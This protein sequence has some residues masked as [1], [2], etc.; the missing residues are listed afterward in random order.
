MGRVAAKT[1]LGPTAVVAVEQYFPQN[2]RILTDELAQ[3]IL[4]FSGRLFLR[5]LRRAWARDWMVRIAA[6]KARGLWTMMLCRKRYID[7]RLIESAAKTGAVINLSAGFDT[8]VYRFQALAHL[9]AWETDQLENIE[10]KRRQLKRIFGAV[11]EHVTLVAI[12]FDRE[13]LGAVLAE[14]GCPVKVPLFFIWEA[15]SQYLCAPA[16]PAVFDRLARATTGSRLAF[17]YVRRDFMAGQKMFG[18]ED[19]Y[20]RYVEN[21]IWLYGMDPE[22]V[23]DF[24]SSYGWR[25]VEDLEYAELAERYVKPTGSKLLT[26]PVE[27]IAYA[28]KL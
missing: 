15:V 27:R 10:L 18:Q 1:G 9:P 24:L 5:L 20:K 2:Q 16:V 4:P 8:R 6:E 3:A 26:M 17:T 23:T 7:E 12:D 14:R 11:P 22:G 19:L 28:E 25:L 21:G 13:D